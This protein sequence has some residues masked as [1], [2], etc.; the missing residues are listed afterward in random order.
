MGREGRLLLGGVCLLAA[1]CSA[2]PVDQSEQ[3]LA[4]HFLGP[5]GEAGIETVVEST[6]HL[7]LPSI[8]DASPWHLEVRIRV[9]AEA[10]R[11]A[12]L[13][14]AHDV[15]LVRDRDPMTVQQERGEPNAGWNGALEGAEGS[16][17][18]ALTRNG[19]EVASLG[20]AGG[21]AEACD[22]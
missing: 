10:S 7:D 12:D 16:S 8:P 5:L 15:V 17:V 4:D 14:E 19:V 13:L 9:D 2:S 6:C 1:A 20:Q 21:W 18:L 3:A 22:P 11:V